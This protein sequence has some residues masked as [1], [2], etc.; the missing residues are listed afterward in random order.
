[1]Y[2]KMIG[3]GATLLLGVAAL[4]WMAP[5]VLA[6]HGGRPGF[7]GGF[8]PGFNRGFEWDVPLTAPRLLGLIG[9]P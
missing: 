9:W 6:Q 4:L 5:P 2:H 3:H 1:M 7:R 8:R